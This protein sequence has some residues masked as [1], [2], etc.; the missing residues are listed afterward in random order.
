MMK[1]K[2]RPEGDQE[3]GKVRHEGFKIL[4]PQRVRL[5]K[6]GPGTNRHTLSRTMKNYKNGVWYIQ[7]MQP[8]CHWANLPPRK[9]HWLS[10][11]HRDFLP[12]CISHVSKWWCNILFW[13]F[14]CIAH[15]FS[16]LSAVGTRPLFLW[17]GKLGIKRLNSLS[18]VA[19]N[20][21]NQRHVF[22]STVSTHWSHG[23]NVPASMRHP[24]PAGVPWSG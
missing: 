7:Y 8:G 13:D 9:A 14:V 18:K 12:Q 15:F 6:D 22:L 11:L 20:G 2:K 17:M 4:R 5:S 23:C 19:P 1:L 24:S 3:L 10:P 16:Q 21:K